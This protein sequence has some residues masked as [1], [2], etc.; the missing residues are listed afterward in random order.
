L[1][2]LVSLRGLQ[3]LDLPPV[4]DDA[5]VALGEIGLVQTLAG[6]TA[7]TGPRPTSA[8]EVIALDLR[9]APIT[10][11]GLKVLAGL[12]NLRALDLRDCPRVTEPGVRALQQALPGCSIRVGE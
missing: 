9:S 5:L 6:A 4:T 10:D 12:P 2:A 3:T 11:T 8:A 1:K 7:G